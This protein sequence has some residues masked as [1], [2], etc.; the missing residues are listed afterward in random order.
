MISPSLSW[1]GLGWGWDGFF[2]QPDNVETVQPK[3]SM[4]AAGEHAVY[5]TEIDLIFRQSLNIMYIYITLEAEHE[6]YANIY[7]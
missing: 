3:R 1:G 6:A 4:Q 2:G 5:M 7:R